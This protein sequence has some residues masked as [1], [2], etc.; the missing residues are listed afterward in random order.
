MSTNEHDRVRDATTTSFLSP[1]EAQAIGLGSIG[2][3]LR[4]SRFARLYRP[5]RIFLGSEV[6]I[7]DFAILSPGDGEIRMAG[8]NHIGAG[9]M[10]F[11]A[12][13]I[14]EWSTV[15]GRVAVY[16]SSDDFVVD[17]ITYPHARPELRAVISNRVDIGSRVVV[18]TGSTILPG[19]RIADGVAVGAMS[20]VTR[21]LMKPGVYAGIP[22]QWRRARKPMLIEVTRS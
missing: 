9:A 14:G 1:A 10:L 13:S 6:R 7:D 16:A 19:V 18:G 15:S 4:L 20:L 5:E 17:A 2:P 21:P 11:G 3:N 12:V 8:H 22:A